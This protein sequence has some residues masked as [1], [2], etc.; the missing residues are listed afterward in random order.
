MSVLGSPFTVEC[1][2]KVT[3]RD[4]ETPVNC[5]QEWEIEIRKRKSKR[6]ESLGVKWLLLR[7]WDPLLNPD[8]SSTRVQGN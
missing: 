6:G 1:P 5:T 8:P 3:D 7:L 4:E 2:R